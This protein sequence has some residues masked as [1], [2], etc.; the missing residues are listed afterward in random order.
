MPLRTYSRPSA[1]ATTTERAFRLAVRDTASSTGGRAVLVPPM[2]TRCTRSAGSDSTEPST[3]TVDWSTQLTSPTLAN[4]SPI[5]IGSPSTIGVP[6]R[7]RS[8]AASSMRTTSPTRET[9]T[10]RAPSAAT[11]SCSTVRPVSH[12]AETVPAVPA[13][14]TARFPG[15]CAAEVQIHPCRSMDGGARSSPS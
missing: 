11:R 3:A 15:F 1:V 14:T 10:M 6:V 13:V 4:P 7:S 2:V 12:G 5:R 9:T 8:T